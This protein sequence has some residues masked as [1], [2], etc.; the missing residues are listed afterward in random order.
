MSIVTPEIIRQ[1]TQLARMRLEDDALIQIA[2]Q[3]DQILGPPPQSPESNRSALAAS[4]S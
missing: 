3:V 4:A 2:G 1:I